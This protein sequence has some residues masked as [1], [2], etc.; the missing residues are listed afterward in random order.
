MASFPSALRSI[1]AESEQERPSVDDLSALALDDLFDAYREARRVYEARF[2]SGL[3]VGDSNIRVDDLAR[4]LTVR[5]T[6]RGQ[7]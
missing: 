4:E 3:D 6:S 2:W 7:R 5:L 1:G